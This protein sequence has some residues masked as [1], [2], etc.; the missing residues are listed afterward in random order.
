MLCIVKSLPKLTNE[1][2]KLGVLLSISEAISSEWNL[3]DSEM[4]KQIDRIIENQ[5]KKT[6]PTPFVL[7][8]N[9]QKISFSPST[10]AKQYREEQKTK[11]IQQWKTA[12]D[13]Y[14]K[15]HEPLKT[16]VRF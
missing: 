9:N 10:T 12:Y 13:N 2:I 14:K 3:F 7:Q 16:T 6:T 8:V 4:K 1:D 11:K 5:L 15:A